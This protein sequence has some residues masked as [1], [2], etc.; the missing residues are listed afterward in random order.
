MRDGEECEKQKFWIG[1]E[2]RSRAKCRQKGEARKRL[3]AEERERKNDRER[4]K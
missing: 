1:R 3:K 4:E 2:K